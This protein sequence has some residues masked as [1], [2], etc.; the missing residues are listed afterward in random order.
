MKKILS[1]FSIT[2]LVLLIINLVVILPLFLGVFVKENTLTYGMHIGV[3]LAKQPHLDPLY[4]LRDYILII[5]ILLINYIFTIFI[6]ATNKN[7]FLHCLLPICFMKQLKFKFKKSDTYVTYGMFALNLTAIILTIVFVS[8]S[9][10][11][12]TLGSIICFT[13]WMVIILAYEFI[14]YIGMIL[15]LSKTKQTKTTA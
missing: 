11:Y 3:P 12:S 8:M 4:F 10:I 1:Y 2:S 14:F 6:F 5:T 7:K 13:I 9:N 15:I